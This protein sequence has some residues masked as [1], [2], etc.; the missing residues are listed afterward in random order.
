MS[1]SSPKSGLSNSGAVPFDE[2]R[3]AIS[4]RAQE[5]YERNGRIPGRDMQNWV[6]A[7]AEILS[8]YAESPQASGAPKKRAIKIRVNGVEYIGEYNLDSAQGYSP[9]EF[10]PG[11]PI[12]VRFEADKMFVQ[13]P[14]GKELETTIVKKSEKKPG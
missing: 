12:H 4:K 10:G 8:E 14:N 6:Q 2:L 3:E 11:D 5:I 1:G 9:G 7:E 13:R